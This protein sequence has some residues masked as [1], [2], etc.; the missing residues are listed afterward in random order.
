[1][2]AERD[3]YIAEEEERTGRPS[4]WNSVYEL[5]QC[6]VRSCQLDSDWCYKLREPHI[7]RLESQCSDGAYKE[8]IAQRDQS[9][10]GSEYISGEVKADTR[11]ETSCYNGIL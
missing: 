1:M 2:L 7:D 11:C 9:I 10:M 3:A 8:A 5:M 4:A 6:N